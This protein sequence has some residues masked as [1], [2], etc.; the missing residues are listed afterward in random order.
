MLQNCSEQGLRSSDKAELT[1][2]SMMVYQSK[3]NAVLGDLGV[4]SVL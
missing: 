2:P 3:R 1:E 4:S